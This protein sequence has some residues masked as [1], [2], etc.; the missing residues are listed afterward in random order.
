MGSLLFRCKDDKPDAEKDIRR[1]DHLSR[2]NTVAPK[3][4]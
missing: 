3:A 4:Y 1:E 2:M